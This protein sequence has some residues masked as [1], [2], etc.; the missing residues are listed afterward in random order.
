M[1]TPEIL[2]VA[3]TLITTHTRVIEL[4]AGVS[5]PEHWLDDVSM[6]FLYLHSLNVQPS[7][8]SALF[9]SR[10]VANSSHGEALIITFQ[11]EGIGQKSH[12]AK[13]FL[14]ELV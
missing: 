8:A 1:A 5:A 2:L 14:V 11:I 3:K 12:S 7:H 6:L 4:N 9:K 13:S 10:R